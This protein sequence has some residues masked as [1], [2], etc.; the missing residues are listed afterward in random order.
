M[1]HLLDLTRIRPL[2]NLAFMLVICF[3]FPAVLVAQQQGEPANE[4]PVAAQDQ[5]KAPIPQPTTPD[6]EQ[7]QAAVEEEVQTPPPA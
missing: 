3:L 7:P 5:Q 2:S 6:S 4:A 1:Y